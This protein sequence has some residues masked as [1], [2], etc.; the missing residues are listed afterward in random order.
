MQTEHVSTLRL[1]SADLP[2]VRLPRLDLR[3]EFLKQTKPLVFALLRK[4][5][6]E[7]NRGGYDGRANDEVSLKVPEP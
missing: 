5:F 1:A 7:Q 2:D 4:R 3:G 6:Q